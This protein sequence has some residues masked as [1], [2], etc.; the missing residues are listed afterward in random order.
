MKHS[1]T[2]ADAA[3]K[4]AKAAEDS[5]V[6]AR[7]SGDAAERSAHVAEETL[8]D[9]RRE[10]AERR[11][12]EEEANRPRPELSIEYRAGYRWGLVN[13]GTAPARAVRC[14]NPPAAMKFKW[15][16]DLVVEPGGVFTFLLM[17][18]VAH[19]AP[20]SLELVWE[21][22]EQPRYLRVPPRTE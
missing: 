15:P 9:H 4:S 16:E 10:A 7:R 2:S 8:A 6:E 14:L 18:S 22:Q 1:K 19:S 21:G 5:V 20:A 13:S 3:E 17:G 12:A 11:A